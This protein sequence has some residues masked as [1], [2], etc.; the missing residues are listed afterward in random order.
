MFESY[1]PASFHNLFIFQTLK[2]SKAF[3][4]RSAEFSPLMQRCFILWRFKNNTI[5]LNLLS[6]SVRN[7]NFSFV[8]YDATLTY[9]DLVS[10]KLQNKFWFVVSQVQVDTLKI[11]QW[12]IINTYV[13]D[14]ANCVTE[15]KKKKMLC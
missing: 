5:I 4:Q 8:T 15:K 9:Q 1:R 7:F 2:D 13:V 3:L 12:A 10:R 6:N 11:L 14:C